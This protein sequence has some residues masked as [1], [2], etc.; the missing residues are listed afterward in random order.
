MHRRKHRP[1]NLKQEKEKKI[2]RYLQ[3]FL[4]QVRDP[5]RRI[6]GGKDPGRSDDATTEDARISGATSKVATDSKIKSQGPDKRIVAIGLATFDTPGTSKTETNEKSFEPVRVN[7]KD[8]QEKSTQMRQNLSTQRLNENEENDDYSLADEPQ[9]RPKYML[10]GWD[11]SR[12]KLMVVL[13]VLFILWA[14]IYFPS[15]GS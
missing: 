14:A 6:S 15:I 13:V 10:I 9:N 5:E 7:S 1:G 12:S 8:I 3:S 2:A 4:S 11:N